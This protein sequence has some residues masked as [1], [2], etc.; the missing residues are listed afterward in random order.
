[1]PPRTRTRA[2]QQDPSTPVPGPVTPPEPPRRSPLFRE[3]DPTTEPGP[4]LSSSPGPSLVDGADSRSRSGALSTPGE[5]TPLRGRLSRAQLKKPLKRSL[6][7]VGGVLANVLAKT[8]GEYEAGLWRPDDED[9]EDI[10][11]PL[12]GIVHRRL[13]AGADNDVLDGLVLLL[14][15]VGYVGKQIARRVELR[16]GDRAGGG[17]LPDWTDPGASD[18]AYPPVQ[19]EGPGAGP[20]GQASAAGELA[21]AAAGGAS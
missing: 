15:V 3:P 20:A 21:A 17:R 11:D 7:I 12:A 18:G 6:T 4:A 13:P 16:A 19:P 1:M 14:A 5:A 9:Q 10:S 2:G 8:Q